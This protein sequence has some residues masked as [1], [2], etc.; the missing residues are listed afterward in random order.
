MIPA[1]PLDAV[2]QRLQQLGVVVGTPNA[3]GTRAKC[4][5][6]ALQIAYALLDRLAAMEKEREL[7][8]GNQKF[9]LQKLSGILSGGNAATAGAGVG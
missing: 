9:A 3:G 2:R 6:E 5:A 8:D 1:P 4:L 7:Y